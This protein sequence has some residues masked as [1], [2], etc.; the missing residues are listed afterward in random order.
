[1]CLNRL[2]LLIANKETLISESCTILFLK[3]IHSFEHGLIT[4]TLIIELSNRMY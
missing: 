2:G 3:I 4:S 1:M